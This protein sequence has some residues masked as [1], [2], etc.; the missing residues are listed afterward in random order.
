M[1]TSHNKAESQWNPGPWNRTNRRN[2]NIKNHIFDQV[3][4][5]NVTDDRN[6]HPRVLSAIRLDLYPSSEAV[7]GMCPDEASH[8]YDPGK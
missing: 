2:V 5:V 6:A 3:I 8:F 7:T 1:V 4:I